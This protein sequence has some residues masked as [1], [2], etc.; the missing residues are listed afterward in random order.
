MEQNTSINDSSSN[1][2]IK[3]NFDDFNISE[4]SFKPVTKGLGFHNDQKRQ[5]SFKQ[6][7]KEVTNFSPTTQASFKNN[8]T[9]LLNDLSK[10][11]KDVTSKTV[12]SGLEAFYGAPIKPSLSE[13]EVNKV[14]DSKIFEEDKKVQLASGLSQFLAWIIDLSLVIS[15]AVIT[16]TLLILVSGMSFSAFLRVIPMQDLA[17]FGAVLFSIYY[18]LYFTVLDLSATPGKTIMGIRVVCTNNKNASVKHTF[19]RALV[20]LLSFIA[21]FLPMVIDFQGRLSETKVIK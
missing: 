17:T 5:N 3:V 20:S 7:P 13:S 16:T 6:A 12:P 21:L 10:N 14:I 8:T 11:N 19:V 18:M 4:D 9:S 15:F 2:P 1:A